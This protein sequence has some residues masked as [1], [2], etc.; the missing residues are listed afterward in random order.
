MSAINK[1]MKRHLDIIEALILGN[2]TTWLRRFVRHS[3]VHSVRER[4]GPFDIIAV[5]VC[6]V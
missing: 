1:A 2:G 6:L 3:A 4:C 5:L